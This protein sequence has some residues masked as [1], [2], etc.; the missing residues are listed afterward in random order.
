M[1]VRTEGTRV[2]K[3]S[4]MIVSDTASS[5]SEKPEGLRQTDWRCFVKA[6]DMRILYS[7]RERPRRAYHSLPHR[8]L[9]HPAFQAREGTAS[10]GDHAAWFHRVDGSRQLHRPDLVVLRGRDAGIKTIAAACVNA[11][12]IVAKAVLGNVARA[13]L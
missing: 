9:A 2:T 10:G 13:H 8:E 12:S 4:A 7:L 6:G 5:I 3:I 11:V 1:V